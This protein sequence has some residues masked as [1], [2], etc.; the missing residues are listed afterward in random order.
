[1]IIGK[2]T[3]DFKLSINHNSNKQTD[4]LKYFGVYLDTK[5][6]RKSHTD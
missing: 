5:L 1:M 6:L 2:K 3:I 4:N